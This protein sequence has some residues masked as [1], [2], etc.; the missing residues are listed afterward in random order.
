MRRGRSR[1]AARGCGAIGIAGLIAAIALG[2][3]GGGSHSAARKHPEKLVPHHRKPVKEVKHPQ[4]KPK[5]VMLV[6]A[7]GGW[8]A[9]PPSEVRTTR[10]YQRRYAALGWIAVDVGYRPGGQQGFTDVKR[11]YDKAKSDHPGLPI[12]AVGESSGGHLALMLATARP[13]DCVE[14]V[15]APTDLTQGLPKALDVEARAVFG[16]DLAKW[17]P[18]LHAKQIHGKVLIVQAASDPVVPAK[19]AKRLHAALPDSE[20]VLLPPGQLTFIH[21]TKVSKS[22]YKRYLVTE[23]EWLPGSR[24]SPARK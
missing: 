11:A 16:S 6:F 20:L 19:Q 7:Q 23:R 1:G 18:L 9:S 4:S 10:H 8:L 17:S 14:P 5:G 22:A 12:C 21:G 24:R 15:D 13:L 3:C 2:G